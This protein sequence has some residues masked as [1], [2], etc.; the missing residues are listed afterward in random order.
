[1]SFSPR[2]IPYIKRNLIL[3][4]SMFEVNGNR[5]I[6]FS[7]I[8]YSSVPVGRTDE[9]DITAPCN[10]DCNCEEVFDP[11]C[12]ANNVMYYTACHAGCQGEIE[13][14][15]NSVRHAFPLAGQLTRILLR[16]T[17]ASLLKPLDFA[18]KL[19]KPFTYRK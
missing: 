10:T 7:C 15:G 4:L 19:N 2:C 3:Q 13:S 1:M 17:R 11:V 16:S 9:I 18:H 8:K 6:L 5:A 12:G 14:D